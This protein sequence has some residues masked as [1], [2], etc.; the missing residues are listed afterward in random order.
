MKIC[1][2]L[3]YLRYSPHATYKVSLDHSSILVL[4]FFLKLRCKNDI[5]GLL[6]YTKQEPPVNC[7]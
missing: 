7:L 4:I 6:E 5:G 1:K 3:F 2:E